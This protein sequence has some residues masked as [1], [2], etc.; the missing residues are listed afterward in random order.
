MPQL[1]FG[2]QQR[3][4]WAP[5]PSAGIQRRNVFAD[6]SSTLDRGGAFSSR[7]VGRHA[8]FDFSFGAREARGATGLD[9]Y[10]EYATGLWDDYATSINGFNPKNMIYFADPMSMR[11]NLFPPHWASPVLSLSGDY[12]P[13]LSTLFRHDPTAANSYRQPPRSLSFSIPHAALTLPTNVAQ[14]FIIPI[15]PGHTLHWGWSGA[16]DLGNPALRAEAHHN[17][18]GATLVQMASPL[19]VTSATRMN[20]T[21]NGDTYDYA[22]FGLAR[23]DASNHNALVVSMM[24]QIWPNGYSPTLTGNHVG[25]VGQTGCVMMGDMIEEYVQADDPGDRRLKGLSFGLLEVG[26]WLV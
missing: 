26:A 20:Q 8:E 1:W 24:A 14:R 21:I 9:V 19:S 3:F 23:P 15:P 5:M 4:Q 22:T 18:G 13:L 2:N 11:S 7:S 6:E 10:Q 16:A 17:A 12:P 25:G